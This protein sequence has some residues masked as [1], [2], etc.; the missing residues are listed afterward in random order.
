MRKNDDAMESDQRPRNLDNRP[1]TVQLKE[2]TTIN[3]LAREMAASLSLSGTVQMAYDLVQ[4]AINP[5][6]IVIYLVEGNKLVS[7]GERADLP[8][9]SK[10]AP[11]TKK[12]G[13]CLCGLVAAHGKPIYSTNIHKDPR[14]VS[15]ECKTAGIRSF[16]SIPLLNANR[17][18]GVF[19]LGSLT[20]RD[21]YQQADYI[22]TLAGH[23]A[24]G[25]RTATLQA[26]IKTYAEQLEYSLLAYETAQ[27]DLKASEKK[28]RTMFENLQ[29][30]IWGVNERDI[31]TFVNPSMARML[32]YP[33]GEMNGK[34]LQ[35]F[36]D[37]A[38]RIVCNQFLEQCKAGKA[39][40]KVLEFIKR[41]GSRLIALIEVTPLFD[42]HARHTG[43]VISV[44]DI[45]QRKRA[46]DEKQRLR[47]QLSEAQKLEAIATLAGG[48]AHQFNN[49]L[50]TVNGCVELIEMDA[51]LDSIS[52][53]THA[54][55]QA[56]GRMTKL[57]N[58]LLSYARG[59]R[60]K[61]HTLSINDFIEDIIPLVRHRLKAGI[62]IETAPASDL[63]TVR[64]DPTQ[65]QM[66]FS[67]V[68]FNAS[69]AIESNGTIRIATSTFHLKNEHRVGQSAIA[70]GLFARV[71]VEDNGRGMTPE[72]LN[73]I[74]EPFFTT[75]FQGRGLG[76]AAA[77][78]IICN[79]SGWI[80]VESK[81]DKGTIVLIHLPATI[82]ERPSAESGPGIL[83]AGGK[84]TILLVDD[85]QTVLEVASKQLEKL[86]YRVIAAETGKQALDIFIEEHED[87]DLVI[88]D[89][90]MPYMGGGEVFDRLKNIN[91]RVKVLLSSGFTMDGEA[92]KVLVRGCRG[93]IQKPFSMESLSSNIHKILKV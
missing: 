88:L 29:E 85:E 63:L 64:A 37:E 31:T 23:V 7:Q 5:D 38:G 83:P 57:T 22:E 33:A 9:F 55:K 18:V 68:L 30:G 90:I 91:P 15:K 78:G 86:G 54:I 19:G 61:E 72:T 16:A 21:F 17:V 42:N 25:I 8:E 93:F 52:P 35:D 44:M 62:L 74:F 32:G 81:A 67:E 48:I 89:L 39:G 50:S 87:I 2:L 41:D 43:C 40:Q 51:P 49:V 58:Q 45:T 77:F 34:P 6:L 73:R 79:H 3:A 13:D 75:K 82:Q 12:I 20:Q 65:L 46:E 11:E 71:K 66:V 70:P 56:V 92:Q 69:E 14:C 26:D 10:H 80:S 53:Y 28:F 84:E 24:M 47:N 76:M 4:T 36:T 1:E 59:G 27:K 60:Y